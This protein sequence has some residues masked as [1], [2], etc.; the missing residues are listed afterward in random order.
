MVSPVEPTRARNLADVINDRFGLATEAAEVRFGLQLGTSVGTVLRPDPR[1]LA[2]IIVNLSG[3]S[4]H[5]GPSRA[6]SATRGIRIP[7]SGGSLQLIWDE[8]F[9][10][11]GWEWYGI[12][13]LA[14][15]DV[16]TLEIAARP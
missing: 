7:A 15:S 11:V 6:V 8:D 2:A 1:R 13:D 3:G 10:V 5:V 9:D 14:A 4:I 12:A 16:Y